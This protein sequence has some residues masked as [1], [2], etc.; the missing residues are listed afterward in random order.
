M[1]AILGRSN[2]RGARG[3]RPVIV[4]AALL[5]VFAISACSTKTPAEQATEAL[6]AG[7][8][9]HVAG[10]LDEAVGHYNDCLKVEATNK[11]CLYN[12]GL[13]AQTQG[14][15]GDAENSYRLALVTD[16]N[17]APAI[18]N[19]AI[20]RTKA[21]DPTEAIALY[22]QFIAL[23]P[24]DASGHLNLGLLLRATGDTKGG[25]AE[26]AIAG[27][28]DPTLSVPAPSAPASPAP[29]NEPQETANPSSS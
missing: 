12:L 22:R 20:L 10:K 14:R 2:E 9:A 13:I 7:L 25:D 15:D 17:Y 5:M 4:L 24:N 16:P 1:S 6:N 19:L 23:L 8:Q 21:G 11:L 27:A 18:F 26:I 28:L 3:R 29:S